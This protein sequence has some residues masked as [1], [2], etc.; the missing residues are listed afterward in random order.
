MKKDTDKIVARNKKANHDYFILDTYECGIVLTGTEIKSVR[1][2][3]V[4]LQ[5][6]YCDIIHNEMFVIGMHIAKYSMGNI[7][8]H[9]ELR[10]RKLLLHRKEILKLFGQVK[11]ESLTIIPLEMYFVEGLAKVKIGLCKGKKLYDKRE[12]LKEKT[13]KR[14]VDESIKRR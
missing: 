6:A 14:E 4:S 1:L 9:E 5:D 2:G 13:R 7:F 3:K 10:K 12:D 8:N 11:Q